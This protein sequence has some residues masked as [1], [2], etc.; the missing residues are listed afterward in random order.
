MMRWVKILTIVLA[1]FLLLGALTIKWTTKLLN[2]TVDALATEQRMDG[3]L[4]PQ[5][6]AYQDGADSIHLVQVRQQCSASVLFV[7]GSPG[8]WEAWK[9]FMADT[10]LSNLACLLA[11]D[12]L[13]YGRSMP[14][15]TET[16]IQRQAAVF[17]KLLEA[18]H[19]FGPIILVGHSYGAP[20]VARMAIDYPQWVDGLILVSGSIDPATEQPRWYNQAADMKLFNWMLPQDMRV[21]N[22]EIM[23]LKPELDSLLPHWQNI[24]M[25]VTIIHGEA[26][27][28][29]P[30]SNLAF[31]KSQLVNAAP[32][33]TVP[34]PGIGHLIP[35]Q[36]PEVIQKA[37]VQML[38]DI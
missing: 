6:H 33:H 13:G 14:G 28:L 3:Q 24:Q 37:I 21:S 7:H 11:V 26:D 15:Q 31:A 25:P 35:W 2:P 32:L 38:E 22:E 18:Q 12:R 34:L 9:G 36:K 16:S 19:R 8:S 30:F 20:V 29:V 10:T 1:T 23:P 27:K 17:A 5:H 4:H